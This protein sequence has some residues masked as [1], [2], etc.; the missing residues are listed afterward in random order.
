MNVRT[1]LAAA[2]L[3]SLSLPAFAASP[4]AEA[5][6]KDIEATL[7]VVPGFIKAMPEAI[8][9]SLWSELKAVSMDPN[10]AIPGKNREL[11]ALGVASQIPCDYC[12]YFHTEAAK[13]NGATQEEIGLAVGGAAA[14]RKW[15]TWFNGMR[16]DEATFRAEIDGFLARAQSGKAP[17]PKPMEVT[18]AASARKDIEQTFG[19]VPTFLRELPDD[20]L[21]GAWNGMKAIEM[22]PKSPIPGKYIALGSLA[23]AS[24]VP[25]T[26][27]TYADTAFA[28]LQGASD[29]E[30]KEAV[31]TAALVRQ[32]STYL[33]GL[34]YD[35]VKYRKEV[36][37]VIA[38][39]K[40]KQG[41]KRASAK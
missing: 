11:I 37:Q 4:A 7:G 26:Y 29:A 15:S 10:G 16:I 14:T 2:I 33:N 12:V 13:L 31:L 5:T 27:C 36:D 39:I 32:F 8:V 20:V 23:V 19:M 30:V 28:K 1:S 9:P 21:P 24:Q 40:K 3:C 18:D 22:N 6:Y 17:E 34:Q 38:A 25:C 41:G 35:A